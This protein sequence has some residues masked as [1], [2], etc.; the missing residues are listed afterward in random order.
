MNNLSYIT[1]RLTQ[2]NIQIKSFL[3]EGHFQMHRYRRRE[4]ERDE[5]LSK[6]PECVTAEKYINH[7]IY[8]TAIRMVIRI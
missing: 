3:A 5:S 8:A 6:S 4:Q 7:V 1:F 2:E